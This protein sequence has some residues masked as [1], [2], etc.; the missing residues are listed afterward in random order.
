MLADKLWVFAA[1]C[2]ARAMPQHLPLLSRS[3]DGAAMTAAAATTRHCVRFASNE[4]SCSS[5]SSYT[6]RRARCTASQ[7][8]MHGTELPYRDA[9]HN[10]RHERRQKGAAF[11]TS[12]RWRCCASPWRK[13]A[14]H[15]CGLLRL[16]SAL[17]GACFSCSR[18]SRCTR[19]VHKPK[20]PGLRLTLT[21][22]CLPRTARADAAARAQPRGL[23][24]ALHRACNAA[25]LAVALPK[26][27]RS[28]DDRCCDHDTPLLAMR[29]QREQL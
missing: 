10:V 25:A 8:A 9:R 20:E 29:E 23:C 6:S 4:S 1:L 17:H 7:R 16:C 12:A 2:T 14:C 15:S 13:T 26:R 27:R 19:C 3:G 24:C 18:F 21:L 5:C 22:A 11:L 28:F